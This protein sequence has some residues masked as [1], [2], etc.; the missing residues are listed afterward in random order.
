MRYEPVTICIS[1]GQ[2][3]PMKKRRLCKECYAPIN[4]EQSRKSKAKKNSRLKKTIKEM[5]KENDILYPEL[6]ELPIESMKGF[7]NLVFPKNY[8]GMRNL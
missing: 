8:A 4:R 7:T 5:M 1:C 3:P 2:R 6:P